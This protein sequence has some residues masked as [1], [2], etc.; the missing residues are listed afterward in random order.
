M[1]QRLRFVF[2]EVTNNKIHDE[3]LMAFTVKQLQEM[4]SY[5]HFNYVNQVISEV[6]TYSSLFS[7]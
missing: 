4:L 1:K 2:V 7:K 6:R 3:V 5:S